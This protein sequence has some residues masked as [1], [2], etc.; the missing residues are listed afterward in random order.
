M[1]MSL[2]HSKIGEIFAIIL[3]KFANYRG[4]KDNQR[5][6]RVIRGGVV[7]SRPQKTVN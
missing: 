6:Y 4:Y 2:Y 7:L 5:E 3:L 1:T